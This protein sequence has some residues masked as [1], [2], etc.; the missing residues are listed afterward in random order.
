MKK[1]LLYLALAM[2]LLLVEIG[3]ALW[4][5]GFVRFYVGDV[6]AA[7]LL[8]CLLR[9]I[10][11]KLHPALPVMALSLLVEAWPLLGYFIA[12]EGLRALNGTFVGT[13]IGTTY[14][15]VD[16][17]CYALGCLLFTAAEYL[18]LHKMKH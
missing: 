15:P 9:S 14:D 17:L 4:A 6:L 7:A 10:L 13:V 11:P 18:L 8:C 5:H 12:G 16:L 2:F 1:R 3:I